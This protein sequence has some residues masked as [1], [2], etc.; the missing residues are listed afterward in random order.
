MMWMKAQLVFGFLLLLLGRALCRRL[1]LP[2]R[3]QQAP[4]ALPMALVGSLH[5]MVFVTQNF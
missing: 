3:R 4:F 2:P 5:Q 1:M